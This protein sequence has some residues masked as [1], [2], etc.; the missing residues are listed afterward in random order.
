MYKLTWT[1]KYG[2]EDIETDIAD[3]KTANYL[4]HEYLLAFNEGAITI[5]EEWRMTENSKRI[6][7]LM[8][9]WGCSKE[10]ALNY[11]RQVE[12]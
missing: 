4:K 10:E 9:D 12:E 11:I 7:T 2:I 3:I 8:D 1:S 5:Q 6:K